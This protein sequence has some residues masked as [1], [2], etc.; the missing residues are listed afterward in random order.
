MQA[1]I[2]LPPVE[3]SAGFSPRLSHRLP[4]ALFL[5]FSPIPSR[6]AQPR[7]FRPMN[8][9]E[10]PRCELSPSIDNMEVM[11]TDT[12]AENFL[13][14]LVK[15]FECQTPA[16]VDLFFFCFQSGIAP[17]DIQSFVAKL[18]SEGLVIEPY[19][20]FYAL[21]GSGYV[22]YRQC[23]SKTRLRR[24]VSRAEAAMRTGLIRLG[25]RWGE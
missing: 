10:R 9:S 20:G 12:L 5:T 21:T 15:N 3:S 16:G 14:W 2:R 25:K 6:F 13:S 22:R 7:A 1:Y 8:C 24:I 4:A 11:A 19:F 17:T 23:P 18:K